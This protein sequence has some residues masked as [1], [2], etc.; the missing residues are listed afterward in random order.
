LQ[1]ATLGLKEVDHLEDGNEIAIGCPHCYQ[2]IDVSP[3]ELVIDGGLQLVRLGDARYMVNFAPSTGPGGEPS[4]GPGRGVPTTLD[5][6]DALDAFLQ[7]LAVP[8]DRRRGALTELETH[9][10]AVQTIRLPLH[11]LKRA[12]LI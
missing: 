8:P 5:G 1:A 11:H 12:H 4:T 6:V 10:V 9:L 2:P 3:E 7:A